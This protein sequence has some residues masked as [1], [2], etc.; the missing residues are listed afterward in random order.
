MWIPLMPLNRHDESEI[1]LTPNEASTF[2]AHVKFS[3][4]VTVSAFASRILKTY[5]LVVAWWCHIWQHRSGSTLA[6]VMA[7]CLTAPSHYLNQSWL[8]IMEVLWYSLEGNFIGDTQDIYPWYE[9]ENYKFETT[10]I[11]PWRQWVKANSLQG[12]NNVSNP[13]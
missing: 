12:L 9:F 3:F 7:C 11:S 8:I 1:G 5:R 10:V 2:P 6:Q 13:K 4:A